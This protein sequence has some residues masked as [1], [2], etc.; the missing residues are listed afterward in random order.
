MKNDYYYWGKAIITELLKNEVKYPCLP[1]LT[2]LKRN[3]QSNMVSC[4]VQQLEMPRIDVPEYTRKAFFYTNYFWVEKQSGLKKEL[5]AF[6]REK[7]DE[8]IALIS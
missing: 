7:I 6:Y 3:I 1:V 5:R 8:A 2:R 4:P